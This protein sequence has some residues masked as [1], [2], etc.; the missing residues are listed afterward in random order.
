MRDR[1]SQAENGASHAALTARRSAFLS[2]LAA[3][4]VIATPA[5]ADLVLSQVI[6]DFAAGKPPRE[7]VEAWNS[8]SERLYVIVQPAEIIDAGQPSEHRVDLTDPTV[9]GLLVT[10]QRLVLE[11]GERRLIRIAV[12]AQRASRDRVFRIVV[13]PVVGDV[14]ASASAIRVLVGYDML[15]ILRPA[16]PRSIVTARRAANSMMLDNSGNTSVELY[17]GKRCDP[18]GNAC[19]A[20]PSRRLYAGATFVQPLPATGPVTY[21]A[22]TGNKVETLNF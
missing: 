7:D 16:E 8:G 15:A 5:H 9:S 18:S 20:L 19:T 3:F 2:A 4:L 12:L 22:R 21:H 13:K 17:D 1:A 11:A 10:P 14:K 6:V